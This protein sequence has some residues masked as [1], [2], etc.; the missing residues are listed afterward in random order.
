MV[1]LISSL[2]IISVR[3]YGSCLSPLRLVVPSLFLNAL[4]EKIYVHSFIH[5]KKMF[6]VATKTNKLI[7]TNYFLLTDSRSL[8]FQRSSFDHFGHGVD[9]VAETASTRHRHFDME[10]HGHIWSP[11]HTALHF[12]CQARGQWPSLTCGFWNSKQLPLTEYGHK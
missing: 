5:S 11:F 4:M 7:Q 8:T 1:S 12:W 3:D 2:I 6:S 9:A 10:E